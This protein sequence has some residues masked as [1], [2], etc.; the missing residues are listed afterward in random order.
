MANWQF[1]VVEKM[2]AGDTELSGEV[3]RYAL[4]QAEARERAAITKE[5]L[6]IFFITFIS[7]TG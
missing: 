5:I 7:L 6:M 2:V 3:S 4:L 1:S